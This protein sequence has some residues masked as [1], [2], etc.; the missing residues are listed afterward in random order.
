M[1]NTTSSIKIF[2]ERNTTY[3]LGEEIRFVI[4]KSVLAI[5]PMQTYITCNLEVKTNTTNAYALN[6]QISSEAL[7]KTMRILSLDGSAVIE[8]I[9]DY[10]KIKRLLAYYGNNKTDNNLNQLFGGGQDPAPILL[11]KNQL[12]TTTDTG[13]ISQV[14]L[15]VQF[16]LSL[17]GILGHTT[18][19][20]PNMLTGLQIVILLENDINKVLRKMGEFTVPRE[21]SGRG[22]AL[23]SKDRFKKV[24]GYSPNMAYQIAVIQDKNGDDVIDGTTDLA[25]L[26]FSSFLLLNTKGV[27]ADGVDD[28]NV[29]EASTYQ[30]KTEDDGAG[31]VQ[32]IL[33]FKVGT[34]LSVYKDD[35]TGS[36]EFEIGS[37]AMSANGRIKLGMTDTAAGLDL[38]NAISVDGSNFITS[39]V[40]LLEPGQDTTTTGF[41]TPSTLEISNM[42]LI[43]GTINLKPEE[44]QK[45]ASAAGASSGFQMD[46]QSY[47]NYPQNITRALVNSVYIPTKLNR[48]K[49]ILSFY[50][51]VGGGVET[52]RDNLL[53][54]IDEFTAPSKYN[55]KINNLIV[56]NRQVSLTNLNKSPQEAG[57]WSSIHLHELQKSLDSSIKVRSLEDPN[58][59]FMVGRQLAVMNHT[60][61]ARNVKGEIRLEL[62]FSHNDRDLLI[63]NFIHHIRRLIISP[64][65]IMVEM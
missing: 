61:D 8:E 24:P 29:I 34:K 27:N 54:I 52:D 47:V 63:H 21:L 56:P 3:Q 28:D 58:H 38:R 2:E 30:V 15:P 6:E 11:G 50:E 43:V 44:A 64:Q 55:Y 51:A 62:D 19:P 18:R 65:G 41:Q 35:G 59:G 26:E 23:C 57:A 12:F 31:L 53:P 40:A 32:A 37:V 14:K 10:N 22:A 60:F 33:P 48:T 7:V 1:M 36:T 13:T 4:P 39:R 17:S 9:T 46:Y 25:K 5:N 45:I 49:S 20:Y 42:E 16:K